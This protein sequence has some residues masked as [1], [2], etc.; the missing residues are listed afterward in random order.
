VIEEPNICAGCGILTQASE[1]ACGS[2][3]TAYPAQPRQAVT[4]PGGGYWVA[5]QASFTCNACRFDSPLNHFEQE[6]NEGVRCTRCGLEQRFERNNWRELVDFAHQ[7]GDFGSGGSQGR[8]PDPEVPITVPNELAELGTTHSSWARGRKHKATPGNPLCRSCKA[9]VVVK[10][11]D[12]D[13]LEVACSGCDE[14]RRYQLPPTCQRLKRLAGVLADEH[15]EGGQ[16]VVFEE[17]D[18]VVALRCPSCAAPLENVKSA[19]GIMVCNYCNAHCRI[20][21]Q[22]HAR[23]GHK[24]TPSKTWWLYFDQPC[25]ERKK[26]LNQARQAKARDE[27]NRHRAQQRKQSQAGQQQSRPAAPAAAQAVKKAAKGRVAAVLGAVIAVILCVGVIFF[28]KFS[29]DSSAGSTSKSG[30]SDKPLKKFSFDM[31]P[32]EAGKL[33][34]VEGKGDMTMKFDTA[35]V[36]QEARIYRNNGKA[37][38]PRYSITIRGGDKFDLEGALE[39]L[40]KVAPNRLQKKAHNYEVNVAKSL[41]RFDSRKLTTRGSIQVMTWVR[42]DER[43]KKLANALW[44]VSRYAAYGKPKPKAEHLRLLNGPTLDV[45]AKLDLSARIEQANTS[46]TELFPIGACLTATDMMTKKTTLTCKVDVDHPLVTE[47]SF[48]W[49]NGAKAHIQ[50]AMFRFP[51][52]AVVPAAVSRCLEQALGAGETIVTDHAAGTGNRAWKLAP[53]G[54]K[55]MLESHRLVITAPKSHTGSALPAWTKRFKAIVKALDGCKG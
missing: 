10:R 50:S 18:G 3:T 15:E 25:S 20:S 36:I 33:F 21:T 55:A 22:S 6:E 49:P 32:S 43:A 53:T 51:K 54:D 45:A 24:E 11:R 41:L 12:G 9:P 35:G 2:C 27:K 26:R 34:G 47:L 44:A 14:V 39:R 30:A 13:A 48:V 38:G 52:R 40:K 1:Q 28:T 37:S 42:Q 46:F 8:F 7:V 29:S 16:E 17:S 5:V 19:D 31:S 23:A 4:Q